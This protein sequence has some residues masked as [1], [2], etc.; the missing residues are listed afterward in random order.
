MHHSLIQQQAVPEYH[1]AT[2]VYTPVQGHF[3]NTFN[4]FILKKL[5]GYLYF[6]STMTKLYNIHLFKRKPV[7]CKMI[8]SSHWHHICSDGVFFL[9]IYIYIYIKGNK[10]DKH[11]TY[12]SVKLNKV[13]KERGPHSGDYGG[14]S[15]MW[16]GSWS[17][18]CSPPAL[19]AGWLACCTRLPASPTT[20]SPE[21]PSNTL[22]MEALFTKPICNG[23]QK[24][25][26]TSLSRSVGWSG[27]QSKNPFCWEQT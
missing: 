18:A 2:K 7:S 15:A 17:T 26:G 4:W 6:L 12:T 25:V 19:L 14:V 13:L 11:R 8:S 9:N 21:V 1:I 24:S 16:T 27:D 20:P 23:T 10:M 3:Q 22:G 5:P